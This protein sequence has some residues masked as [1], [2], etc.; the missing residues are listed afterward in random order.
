MR[1]SKTSHLARISSGAL[2]QSLRETSLRA[3]DR[4]IA[5]RDGFSE[6]DRHGEPRPASQSSRTS[7]PTAP[8]G[9]WLSANLRR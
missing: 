7:G 4:S 8:R 1:I 2:R 9:S 3:G 5:G 6:L